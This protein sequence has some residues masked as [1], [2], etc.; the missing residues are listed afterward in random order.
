MYNGKKHANESNFRS[1]NL[2]IPITHGLTALCFHTGRL[3]SKRNGTWGSLAPLIP[4]PAPP[5]LKKKVQ[6]ANTFDQERSKCGPLT[7]ETL[8]P[9]CEKVWVSPEIIEQIRFQEL[10][11]NY[12]EVLHSSCWS[13]RLS[14]RNNSSPTG[15]ISMKF[16][17]FSKIYPENSLFIKIWQE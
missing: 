6:T 4:S 16:N 3:K 14:A 1:L 13:V 15:W 9:V 17:I 11:Q 10:L 12:E 2:E 7:K 5:P 8:K